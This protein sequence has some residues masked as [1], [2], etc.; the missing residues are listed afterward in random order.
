MKLTNESVTA[1]VQAGLALTDPES[2]LID[3][4][5]KHAGGLM[6]LRTLLNGLGTGQL[7][8]VNPNEP[9]DEKPKD[10]KN[11]PAN[12]PATKKKVRRKKAPAKK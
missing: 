6:V 10:P 4:F 1:A 12:P 3:V 7:A 8:L 2:D 5:R 11:P 9:K